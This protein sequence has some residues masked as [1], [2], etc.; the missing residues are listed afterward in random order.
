MI[1][2]T[3]QRLLTAAPAALESPAAPAA[4]RL[5]S[6]S[7]LWGLAARPALAG[8]SGA[9]VPRQMHTLNTPDRPLLRA[10]SAE[11]A[12]MDQAFQQRDFKLLDMAGHAL[13]QMD[14]QHSCDPAA[15]AAHRDALAIAVAL[16]NDAPKLLEAVFG[17][18]DTMAKLQ[19]HFELPDH[20]MQTP[21]TL[22][23]RC[24]RGPHEN[25][26][27][28]LYSVRDPHASPVA[29]EVFRAL[30]AVMRNDMPA[31]QQRLAFLATPLGEGMRKLPAMHDTELRRGL[32]IGAPRDAQTLQDLKAQYRPGL[33]IHMGAPTTGSAI[34]AYPG[35]VVTLIHSAKLGSQLRDT[36]AFSYAQGQKEMT[37]L[38]G[39]RVAVTGCEERTVPL[40]WAKAD[41]LVASSGRAW[42]DRVNEPV[43]V[44]R[45]RELTP[46]QQRLPGADT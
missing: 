30:N 14:G 19:A 41:A 22:A 6:S 23:C 26:A 44:V 7:A 31:G 1:R 42:G 33:Q 12:R 3:T 10:V 20:L 34:A 2:L 39:T 35:N 11:L 24:G 43:L 4:Q 5:P 32:Q 13:S 40:E 17:G 9:S 15:R 45:M 21:A 8:S 25:M 37:F 29:P 28:S 36:S 27:L 46:P 16:G 18:V 38:P